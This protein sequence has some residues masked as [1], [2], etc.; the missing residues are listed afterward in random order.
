MEYIGDVGGFDQGLVN[1]RDASLGGNTWFT[2]SSILHFYNLSAVAGIFDGGSTVHIGY[3]RM[4][5][6]SRP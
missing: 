4:W 6:E 5:S 3:V 1:S 2:D